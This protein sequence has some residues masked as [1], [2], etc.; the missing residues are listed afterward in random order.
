MLFYVTI[1][2][3][4]W[5]L[6]FSTHRNNDT[7]AISATRIRQHRRMMAKMASQHTSMNDKQRIDD[8]VQMITFSETTTAIYNIAYAF[9]TIFVASSPLKF[10]S[11]TFMLKSVGLY[12][13]AGHIF[14]L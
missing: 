4:K 12:S 2:P 5:S 6:N 7:P 8:E 1:C 9:S 3:L 10:A 14:K 13:A 11:V